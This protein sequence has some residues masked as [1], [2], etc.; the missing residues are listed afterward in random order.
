MKNKMD[1]TFDSLRKK[2][3]GA[4]IPLAPGDKAPYSFSLELVDLFERAGSD[5]V[6]IAIPTRYPWMEGKNMQIHQLEAIRDGVHTSDSFGLMETAHRKHPNLPLVT[7]NFM[8]PVFGYGINRYVESCEKAGI[9]A[10]DVPDYPYVVSNDH[11][12]FG[13]ELISHNAHFIID[14]TLDVATAPEDSAKSR[15]LRELVKQS[16]GFLFL[17]AQPGG[18]SGT[19]DKLPS[20]ELKPAC[21]RIRR[22]EDE[23]GVKTPIIIVCGI[24]TP[25]QV[26]DSIRVVGAD[27]VM[28]GSAVSKRLQAG[29]SLEK[30]EPF[31]KSLKDATRL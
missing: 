13:R 1:E 17:I 12:G 11:E 8:G 7:I 21:E 14:V 5:I 10:V 31:V 3:E 2:K 30:I 27:G 25:E 29:E 23:V 4:L 28:L 16:S 24:S 26:H 20:D 18:V 22:I 15:L 9:V 6:E 19:K